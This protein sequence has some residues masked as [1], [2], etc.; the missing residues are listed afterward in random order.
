MDDYFQESGRAGRSGEFATS[1]IFWKPIDTSFKK[2]STKSH[3][4]ELNSV[5]KYLERCDICRRC[6]LLEYFDSS[7]VKTLDRRDPLTCCDVCVEVHAPCVHKL[8]L[9]D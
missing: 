6:Q 1:T 9:T 4:V 2:D 5:R 7:I 8:S 3:D